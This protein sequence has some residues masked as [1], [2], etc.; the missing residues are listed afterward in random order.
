MT[1]FYP[2][3]GGLRIGLEQ[4]CDGTTWCLQFPPNSEKRE[5][6]SVLGSVGQW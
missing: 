4:E 2:A 3:V 6:E 1:E 5:R